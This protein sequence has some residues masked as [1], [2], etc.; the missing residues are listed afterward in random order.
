MK[1]NRLKILKKCAIALLAAIVTAVCLIPFFGSAGKSGK[2]Q[3][4]VDLHGY[5]PS[6]SRIPTAEDPD[7]FN[8]TYYIAEAFMKENPDVEIVWARTKPVGGMDSEVAQ[9]F[10]TQIAGGTVPAVAFSWGTRYQDRDWYLPLDEYLDD[11]WEYGGGYETWRDVFRDYIWSSN[12]IVNARGEIVAIPVTVYPGAS[13]GYFYNKTAFQTAG[14][15]SVPLTW[16]QFIEATEKLEAAGYVGV[17][18]WMYFD[19]TTTFD[20]WVFQSVVSPSYAGALMDVIDYDG[21]GI[22]SSAEQARACLEGVFSTEHEYTKDMYRTLKYYYT[23]MLKK[24][25]ASIDYN[26]P[27]LNGEVGIREEGLW[28]IPSEN[29]N[30]VRAFDYGVFVAPPVST[31]S[32]SYVNEVEYSDGPYQPG[33][34]LSLN[35][36][37][38]AVEDDPEMLDAA[39]R[40][41]KFLTKPENVSLICIEN[42]G[43]LGAVKGTGHSNLID[44]FISQ[45]F[46]IKPDAAWPAGFTDEYGDRLNRT[47]ERWVNGEI[48][49][50]KFYAQVDEIQQK[51]AQS[52]VK[53]MGLDTSGW[54]IGG[55]K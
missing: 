51:G 11:E 14:V 49:D 25:W 55:A 4:V 1:E 45:K 8:S 46:P 9:W 26:A 44:E 48:A 2:I 36:M 33:P 52:F 3:L 27:W 16:K 19:T 23:N 29:S 10:T 40:F 41:L 24:G 50:E 13:T 7:V 35:I 34:D 6:V 15:E 31:D 37:K 5:T 18:P 38:A 22:M 20:A 32:S 47:F 17:A 53:N 54:N 21:N 43:V 28:A 12:S 30:V 39:V 42:A